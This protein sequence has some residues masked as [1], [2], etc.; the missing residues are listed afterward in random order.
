VFM[1]KVAMM[2]LGIIWVRW[3]WPRLRFDQLMD[4][5]WG[6]L[7]PLAMGNVIFAVILLIAGW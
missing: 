5:S 1:G 7:I 3:M 4:L 2:V 6:R